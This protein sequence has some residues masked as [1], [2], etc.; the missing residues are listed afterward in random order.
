M[1]IEGGE[2]VDMFAGLRQKLAAT[3]RFRQTS[4]EARA[5]LRGREVRQ[6][7]VPARIRPASNARRLLRSYR[8]AFLLADQLVPHEGCGASD[9]VGCAGCRAGSHG[10]DAPET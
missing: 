1:G 4:F 7:A 9:F 3:D 2:G 6:V 8:E 5:K 10:I